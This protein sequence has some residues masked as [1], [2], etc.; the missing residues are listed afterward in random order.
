MEIENRAKK[1]TLEEIISAVAILASLTMKRGSTS[2][3]SNARTP[4]AITRNTPAMFP[5]R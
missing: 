4:N 5:K 1:H 3:L 2:F